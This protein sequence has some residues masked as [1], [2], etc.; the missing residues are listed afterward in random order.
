MVDWR[1]EFTDRVIR[2]AIQKTKKLDVLERERT[3]IPILVVFHSAFSLKRSGSGHSACRWCCLCTR[4]WKKRHRLHNRKASPYGHNYCVV[5]VDFVAFLNAMCLN[6][7][8]HAPKTRAHC[9]F[10]LVGWNEPP[11]D[12]PAAPA[13][14]HVLH[15]FSF[16]ING[17]RY[18]VIRAVNNMREYNND[19]SATR[20]AANSEP[21]RRRWLHVNKK[22]SRQ[23]AVYVMEWSNHVH[24]NS[25]LGATNSDDIST[26][27]LP[28]LNLG[29]NTNLLD[30]EVHVQHFVDKVLLSPDITLKELYLRHCYS[31]GG[32]GGYAIIIKACGTNTKLQVLD[33]YRWVGNHHPSIRDQLIQSLPGMKGLQRLICSTDFFAPREKRWRPFIKKHQ[34]CGAPSSLRETRHDDATCGSILRRNHRLSQVGGLLRPITIPT[35]SV[36][37]GSS[38]QDIVSDMP[39]RGLW[40]RVLAKVGQGSQEGANPTFMILKDRLASWS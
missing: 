39:P 12:E 21:L 13:P 32:A 4:L 38:E 16:V 28:K 3:I 27:S 25:F 2:K 14:P 19:P 26:S 35:F 40:T 8:C 6:F 33:I 10:L 36:T 17:V 5:I 34:H 18:R 24:G 22:I 23:D 31:H 9:L 7:K 20:T 15:D 30:N 37:V 1:A 11:N 29:N